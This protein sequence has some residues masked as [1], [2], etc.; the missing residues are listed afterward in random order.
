[1]SINKMNPTL[2]MGNSVYIDRERE[3]VLVNDQVYLL[4]TMQFA[5]LDGLYFIMFCLML[6][7]LTCHMRQ[8]NQRFVP[9]DAGTITLLEISNFE[10]STH[11]LVYMA[12]CQHLPPSS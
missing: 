8:H 2:F 7:H 5:L 6:P 12:K 3:R 1:M 11:L 4:I 9:L 10:S